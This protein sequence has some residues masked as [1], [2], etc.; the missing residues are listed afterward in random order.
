MIAHK[1]RKQTLFYSSLIF[2]TLYLRSPGRGS[3]KRKCTWK[4]LMGQVYGLTLHLSS[5]SLGQNPVMWP[6][7]TAKETEKYILTVN[8]KRIGAGLVLG[9]GDLKV[10]SSFTLNR[11][12]KSNSL[13][14]E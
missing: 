13:S 12:R 2:N 1:S 10:V 6:H 7:L 9:A 3:R 5:K 11:M 14:K 4:D 8:R